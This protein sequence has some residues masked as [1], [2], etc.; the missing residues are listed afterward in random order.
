MINFRYV[1]TYI[2]TFL[3]SAVLLVSA[4]DGGGSAAGSANHAPVFTGTPAIVQTAA[5]V[6][7][8]LTLSGTATSDVDGDTVTLSYQ[9]QANG[10]NIAGATGATYT[11]GTGKAG[12]TITAVITADDG[13]GAAN[14]TAT[15]TTGGLLITNTAPVAVND[16]AIMA[17]DTVVTTVNVLLNDTDA[18]GDTLSVSAADA[19]SVSGGA[20]A[21]NNDGTFNYTP[22]LNFNG[23]DTFTYTASDGNG[24]TAVGTVTI[25]V[26]P[27]NDA[28]VFTGTPAI[29]QTA[30]H[31]GTLLTLSGTATSD[32][33]GDTVTLS[34]QWQ[35]NGVN[36]AGAT[37]AT[38]TVGTGKA[39]KTITA[40]IT[41]DDGTGAANAT[42]SATTAGILVRGPFTVN[43]TTDTVDVNIGDGLCIDANGLCSLRAAMQ[44]TNGLAGMDTVIL[45]AGI[46][47]LTQGQ[48]AIND[49][50]LLSGAGAATA[51]IDGNA[52]GR[53]FLIASGLASVDLT[54][55]TLRNGNTIRGAGIQLNGNTPTTISRA[56]IRDN[57]AT[58]SGGAF[59]LQTNANLTL[60]DSTITGNQSGNSPGG[61][62]FLVNNG[63]NLTIRS[64]TISYNRLAS[65]TG[66]GAGVILDW[67]SGLPLSI[68]IEN[69]TIAGNDGAAIRADS[70]LTVNI[71]NSTITNNTIGLYAGATH[72]IS[73][74]NVTNSILR[75]NGSNCSLN[76]GAITSGGHNIDSGNTCG[77][78]GIGDLVNTDS[79]L[80]ALR[81]NGGATK[82]QGLLAGSPAIDAGDNTICPATDQRGVARTDGA[83]DIGAVEGAVP[84]ATCLGANIAVNSTTDAV[85][86]T[87][88][89]GI[90]NDGSG[91]C[92]LRA[93]IQETNACLGADIIDVSAGAYLLTIAGINENAAATG[94]LD[95]TN[96]L[97]ING[98][99]AATTIIDASNAAFLD[100]IFHVLNS[101]TTAFDGLTIQGAHGSWGLNGGGIATGGDLSISNAVISGNVGGSG[102]G[103]YAWNAASTLTITNST[104]S[105]NT[106]AGNGGAIY[107]AGTLNLSGSTLS[108]NHFPYAYG[109][110]GAAIY[111]V[112]GSTLN[113]TGNTLIDNNAAGYAEAVY[114]N[115]NTTINITNSTISNSQA[116]T[117]GVVG[118]TGSTVNII[119]STFSGNLDGGLSTQGATSTLNVTDSTFSGNEAHSTGGS[120]NGAGAGAGGAFTITGSTFSGNRIINDGFGGSGR[121]AG[122]Y[123]A[124]SAAGTIANSTFSGNHNGGLFGWGG[125]IGGNGGTLTLLNSTLSGNTAPKGGNFGVQNGSL[126]VTNTIF[127]NGVCNMFYMTVTSGGHNIDSGN[128]CGLTAPTDL[129]TTNPL[130]APLAA[131]GGPTQ[132]HALLVGSP[133]IDAADPAAAPI[134]DQRGVARHGPPD[135]GAYEF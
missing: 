116:G 2:R 19:T 91:N 111:G 102:D 65:T 30:A 53:I 114:G 96:D 109:H 122:F 119:R 69:S 124:S 12:K 47:I 39:G 16:A 120:A 108:G 57:V 1:F 17:E 24:G 55:L 61:S 64:S 135:V 123:L 67:S 62:A 83:C 34:Y 54:D 35:A 94:D 131:N 28:P 113:I 127:S 72:A 42:T 126:T 11:V 56:I 132:T 110:H 68:T 63:V 50:L 45:P 48:L 23:T 33:D 90:C 82:T 41:A 8:L 107:V 84:F 134:T 49:A 13:T 103:I 32:V 15:A 79:M 70:A 76:G 128:T 36:I 14:A 9:W 60:V 105:N 78:A 22:A 43:T 5:H 71:T 86:A 6:G 75:R 101:A 18:D 58:N 31:V 73:Q 27:V 112:T 95:I 97:T 3:L 59:T 125:A 133:A 85:D 52:N 121:G 80:G 100:R 46:Y 93:A 37:G 40:V 98:G 130:L 77:F 51:I 26:T 4:C 81:N 118:G 29:V 20:V 99:G 21:N 92:T 106:G 66:S 44:E 89:D 74:S 88:G 115:T 129:T 117:R 104:L 87:I 38:Y 10:V 7:T 25:T